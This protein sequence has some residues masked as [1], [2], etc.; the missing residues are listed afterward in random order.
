MGALATV[1]GRPD[2]AAL[3]TFLTGVGLGDNT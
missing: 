1:Q 2:G 3:H